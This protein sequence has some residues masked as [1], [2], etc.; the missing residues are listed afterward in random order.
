MRG[1]LTVAQRK[2]IT[3][4]IARL[5]G[6][7]DSDKH[8][9]ELNIYEEMFAHL[10]SEEARSMWHQGVAMSKAGATSIDPAEFENAFNDF[11]ALLDRHHAGER[12]NDNVILLLHTV[13]RELG[14]IGD[15]LARHDRSGS[16]VDP[17]E[18]IRYE[19]LAFQ[20]V[21]GRFSGSPGC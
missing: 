20:A 6:N 5:H 11:E 4:A 9:G 10:P 1:K 14:L 12:G 8:A 16:E 15:A 19:V 3:V 7:A 2:L 13:V 21:N 17:I 18:A